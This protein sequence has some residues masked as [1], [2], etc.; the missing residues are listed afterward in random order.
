MMTMIII[1]ISMIINDYSTEDG[2]GSKVNI[3]W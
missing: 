2:Q 3:Y 1:L